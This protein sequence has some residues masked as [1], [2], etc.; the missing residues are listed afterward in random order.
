MRGGEVCEFTC[1]VDGTSGV[2]SFLSFGYW[3]YDEWLISESMLF[4][5]S[6]SVSPYA[7]PV[8]TFLSSSFIVSVVR[9]TDY[10]NYV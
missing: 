9:S 3:M 6:H 7:L 2:C 5:L 1:G 10:D 4:P 8:F